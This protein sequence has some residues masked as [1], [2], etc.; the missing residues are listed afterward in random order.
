MVADD[1]GAGNELQPSLGARA[2]ATGILELLR[3]HRL[4]HRLTE[5]EA[6]KAA[7]WARVTSAAQQ[8][9]SKTRRGERRAGVYRLL[10]SWPGTASCSAPTSFRVAKVDSRAQLGLAA[11]LT[12][13]RPQ[14]CAAASAA[15]LAPE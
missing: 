1:G 2:A 7:R 8:L 9:R 12:H 4:A 5:P 14:R 3:K 13:A 15:V 10:S 6:S 11:P